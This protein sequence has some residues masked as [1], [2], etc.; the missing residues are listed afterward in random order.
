[1]NPVLTGGKGRKQEETIPNFDWTCTLRERNTAPVLSF[2]KEGSEGNKVEEMSGS[3]WKQ[4]RRR[5]NSVEAQKLERTV[6]KRYW[7]CKRGE[8]KSRGRAEPRR[9]RKGGESKLMRKQCDGAKGGRRNQWWRKREWRKKREGGNN[10]GKMQKD[11]EQSDGTRKA[12]EEATGAARQ[13]VKG[14]ERS[15]QQGATD[16]RAN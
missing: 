7:E 9:R 4:C 3:S 15:N 1:M 11:V 8:I 14:G 16:I 6:G 13:R 2:K 10:R 12:G 5:G